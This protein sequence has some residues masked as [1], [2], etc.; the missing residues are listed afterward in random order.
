MP[1][2]VHIVGVVELKVTAKPEVAVALTVTG[3]WA[4]ELLARAAKVIVWGTAV[5]MKLCATERCR[6]IRD[7][8]ARLVGHDA[9]SPRAE[10]G[11]GGLR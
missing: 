11:D 4:D 10:Q 1:P 7:A 5:T 3:V 9:A 6:G 8:V 2:D